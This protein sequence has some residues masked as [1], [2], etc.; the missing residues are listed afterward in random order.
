[1]AGLFDDLIPSQNG[2]GLSFADLIMGKHKP[3][4]GN[5]HV[6]AST[7]FTD[8]MLFGLP[9]KASAALNAAV[10][11]PFTDKSF[12]E[13]YNTLRDQYQNAR[14]QYASDHPVANTAASIGGSLYGGAVTGGAAGNVIGRVAP[15]LSQAIQ[16]SYG[17][18]MAADAASGAV[19]GG[20]SAY[21]HD[22]NVGLGSIIGGV[23][24]GLSRPVIDAGSSVLGS[25][26]G[27]VGVGN[28]SRANSAI[29]QA[30]TR[31]DMSGDDVANALADAAA[32]GQPYTVADAMGN[33]GQ[34][35]LT[36]I[37]RSPGDMRQTIAET[38]QQRQ[39]GQGRRLQNALVEGF[40]TPQTATQTQD[41]LTAL[42]NTQANANYDAARQA[43]GTVDPS[44]AI[45]NADN[46][47]QP[48]ASGVM[49]PGN[50]ISDDSIEA[51]VRRARGYL[52]DGNSVLTDFNAALRAK[53][54]M[55]AMIEGAKPAV[56]R[57]LIP[58][59]D[60]LDNSLAA[61]SAPYATARD[62]FRQ[63]SQAIE[64]ADVGR[65]AAMRGRTEDTIPAFQAMRPDQQASYRAGYV[66]PYIADIQK[67]AGPMT[68]KARPLIS[69]AT[70]AEFPAFAAPGEGQQLMDRI[71]REQRMHET[72]QAAL[73][74]SRTADNAADMADVQ[75]F[76]PSMISAF[77]TGGLKGA[78]LHGLTKG[79]NA[80]QGRNQATRDAIARALLQGDPNIARTTLN[81]AIQGTQRSNQLNNMIVRALIGGASTAYPRF[82]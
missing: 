44:A 27:L 51:A 68:N 8:E 74:G 59:R 34:R 1:M 66:D 42:R 79:I 37:A 56:Q 6:D 24:G 25:L 64:A 53:Q 72:M 36:G 30:L 58:I 23:A 55:D 60:A 76:D 13:E 11:A 29:T 17:G 16:A 77:A 61:T 22:Q 15:A 70:A 18:R 54:E 4:T 21:G 62:T 19:Q 41:A 26:G 31:A 32:A 38:L 80:V 10:R 67:A 12:S 2:G 81:G 14:Q 43:A 46:F 7:V 33:S 63:Q 5:Q 57:Q 75:G 9:G 71:A 40:G 35:M 65:N 78:A 52:T 73:G 82:Q 20:L 49:N 3:D 39:A 47:L 45:Q 28:Q 69:D 48:G 50:N